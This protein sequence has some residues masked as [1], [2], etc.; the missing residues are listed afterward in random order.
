[1]D[2]SPREFSKRTDIVGNYLLMRRGVITQSDY[3][4]P[5]GFRAFLFQRNNAAM[6]V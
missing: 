2:V 1:M 5:L 4:E 3:K 6:R